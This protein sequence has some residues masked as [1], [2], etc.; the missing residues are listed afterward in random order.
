MPLFLMAEKSP[1]LSGQTFYSDPLLGAWAKPTGIY[2]PPTVDIDKGPVNVLLWLHGWYVPSMEALFNSDPSA[3]RQQILASSKRVI[4]IAPYLGNGHK[5]GGSTYSV[6]DLTGRW[7]ERYLDEVLGSLAMM[8]DPATYRAQLKRNDLSLISGF[9]PPSI[10]RLPLGKLVI[11][12]HSGGGE[13][14]R[15]LVDALGRY[16]GHLAECW[17][18]D[19]LNRIY[20]HPDDATFWYRWAT[21]TNA[22]PLYVSYGSSTVPQSVK[23]Y[24]MGEGL[25]TSDGA[26]RDPEGPDVSAGLDVTLGISSPKYIDDLLGLDDLLM[27]TTPRSKHPSALGNKFV[28]QAA[29]NLSKNAGWPKDLMGMHYQIARDG[30]LERLKAATFL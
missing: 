11:A 29:S 13:G 12:C 17:G 24:L 1:T 8:E 6:K 23:L 20:P 14:M 18:F 26:R 22:R 30:L 7:G 25:A 27:A 9:N 10:P 16:K 3:V 5:G 21:G 19:C 28:E 15:N 2:L 4:L